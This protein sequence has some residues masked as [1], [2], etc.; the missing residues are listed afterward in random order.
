MSN[1]LAII[2][3]GYKPDYLYNTLESL[4][5]QSNKDFTVYV[6]DDN[7]PYELY[8]TVKQFK[9]KLDIQYVKF[10]DNLGGYSLIKQW[11]RCIDLSN[12]EWIWLFS[13]DD[14]ANPNCVD[15]FYKG[16]DHASK[17]YKFNTKIIDGDGKLIARKFDKINLLTGRLSSQEFIDNR[18]ASNGFRSFAVEYIFHRDLYDKHKFVEFPLAWASDDA[19]WLLYSLSNGGLISILDEIVLWRYSGKNISSDNVNFNVIVKKIEA[20]SQYLKW[21]KEAEG[22]YKIKINND[23]VLYWLSMQI[24]SLPYPITLKNFINMTENL[25]LDLQEITAMKYFSLLMIQRLKLKTK[26]ILMNNNTVRDLTISK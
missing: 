6:G 11:E 25:G 4:C 19:T 23:K 18:L 8:K 22:T 14:I 1:N 10:D 12:E 7:S 13:D 17:L 20:S 2:I 15:T 21:L 16:I 9:D 3:P 24:A 26:Y 5:T